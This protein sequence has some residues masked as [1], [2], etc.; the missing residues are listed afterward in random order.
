MISFRV[1]YPFVVNAFA[2]SYYGKYQET[3]FSYLLIFYSA[4]VTI[5]YLR[6]DID[7]LPAKIILQTEKQLITSVMRLIPQMKMTTGVK[8]RPW[9]NQILIFLL[10]L[11]SKEMC[12]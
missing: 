1:N 12:L 2:R 5:L 7:I 9:T 11:R 8:S 10:M 3:Q 6:E 4:K